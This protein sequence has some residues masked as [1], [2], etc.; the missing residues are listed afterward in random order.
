MYRCTCY[1]LCLSPRKY[2]SRHSR[3]DSYSYSYTHSTEFGSYTFIALDACPS[4][5]PRR[6]LNFFGV[7]HDVRHLPKWADFYLYSLLGG[8][9]LYTCLHL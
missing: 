5:G 3:H 4:P 2:S 9:L 7:L 6:P 8:G 1:L